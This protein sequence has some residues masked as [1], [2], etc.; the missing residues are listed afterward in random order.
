M[1]TLY[2]AQCTATATGIWEDPS[3]WSCGS[4]PGD[5]DGDDVIIPFGIEVRVTTSNY[6]GGGTRV[7][8]NILVDGVLSFDQGGAGGRPA[9]FLDCP[10]S[11]TVGESGI[12]S[13]EGNTG[14][15]NV[16]QID[17]GNNNIWSDGD[18]RVIAGPR[19]VSCNA[20]NGNNV[21]EP[22]SLCEDDAITN[23]PC[24]VPV[25]P[26]TEPVCPVGNTEIT[27]STDINGTNAQQIDY[28]Y[29]DGGTIP[30]L[31]ASDVGDG[32][33]VTFCSDATISNLDLGNNEEPVTII[34]KS[35]TTL[36][37]DSGFALD[38]NVSILN[39]GTIIINGDV[40]LTNRAIR[41]VN[42]TPTALIDINGTLTIDNEGTSI[43]NL[44]VDDSGG[45]IQVDQLD[46]TSQADEDG[47]VLGENSSLD[48]GTFNS[49]DRLN[50][51]CGA[52]N[53]AEIDIQTVTP[54]GFTQD[55]TAFSEVRYCAQNNIDQVMPGSAT[56]QC[57]VDCNI[58]LPI[59]LT[60]F[61]AEAKESDVLL[62]WQTASEYNNY[63]FLVERSSNGNSFQVIGTIAGQGT[64]NKVQNYEWID[65]AP[66]DGGNYYRL[67]QVDANGNYSFSMIRHVKSY[68]HNEEVD[69][70]PNPAKDKLT[71]RLN[72][73]FQQVKLELID[74]SGN[75]IAAK[76]LTQLSDSGI[77]WNGLGSLKGFYILRVQH[78]HFIKQYK[79]LFL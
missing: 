65:V 62:R 1:H 3:I 50:S 72:S 11:V 6:T 28:F 36:T 47:V 63:Q 21:G 41:L 13:A 16:I 51:I 66:I 69:V 44:G 76:E 20:N 12:I 31:S 54:G 14:N 45:G 37:I 67:R 10:S 23:F 55:M 79:I 75:I 39:Y 38:D 27:G 59:S 8:M 43:F 48:V 4:V 58:L 19:A 33:V 53:C 77:V 9:L 46:I 35:G 57:P 7:E 5:G 24:I 71:I 56:E 64:I 17:P 49:N 73:E 25:L 70:Y 2:A 29:D 32:S 61:N 60:F 30:T 42:A 74:L 40:D 15:N 78:Q 52:Q 18:C 34:V 26:P 68:Y 22:S